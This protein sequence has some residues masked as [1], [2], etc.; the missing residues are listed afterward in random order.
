MKM[1]TSTLARV[2]T[3]AFA[4]VATLALTPVAS[5]E[6]HLTPKAQYSADAKAALQRY[7]SDR[8]LCND[9]TSSSARLQCR[10]DAKAQYDQALTEAK[11]RMTTTTAASPAPPPVQKM[12]PVQAAPVCADCGHV[13]AVSTTEKAG[14]G[15]ALGMIAGGAAGAILGHQV[16][17]GTGK[18][19]ATIAGAVGGAYAGKKIEENAKKHTLWS[20]I[21]EYNDGSKNSYEFDHDPGFKVGDAVKKSGNTITR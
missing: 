20:V 10:R 12:T 11:A 14:E 1:Q 8:K 5:A 2:C 4:L 7:D 6:A 18:D 15:G 16:G 3:C 19:L 13:T 17:Q 21:V 9:E